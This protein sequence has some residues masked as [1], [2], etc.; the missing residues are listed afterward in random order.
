MCFELLC[1]DVSYV[2]KLPNQRL[3]EVNRTLYGKGDVGIQ[4]TQIHFAMTSGGEIPT[5]Y[6]GF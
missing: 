4:G 6:E 1:L 3:E 2:V 5:L